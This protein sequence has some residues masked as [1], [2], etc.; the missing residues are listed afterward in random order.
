MVTRLKETNRFEATGKSGRRYIIIESTLQTSLGA[1][2]DGNTLWT[3]DSRFLRAVNFGPVS[4]ISDSEFQISLSG[5]RLTRVLSSWE[6]I[7]PA[8]L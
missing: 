4:Q 5:E 1:L 2:D 6:A 8:D 7:P 3:D